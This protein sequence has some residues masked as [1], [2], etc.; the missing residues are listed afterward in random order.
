M[1]TDL[2]EMRAEKDAFFKNHPQS[3]LTAAQRKTFTGLHYFPENPALRLEVSVE[4]FRPQPTVLMQTS[5]GEAREYQK[6]GKFQFTVEG[7]TTALTVYASEHGFFLP[8]VDAL[9]EVET[10]G[11]GRYLEPESL[12]GDRFLVDF[13][14]AY[15]PYCAY[16]EPYWINPLAENRWSCPIT[17]QENRLKIPIRAGEKVYYP[18]E[19][20]EGH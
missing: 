15:N 11:A 4:E 12:D 6:F 2:A 13:N 14:L 17:P 20:P 10:Y 19:P 9:A 7:Q 16:N 3:P 8:F 5:T 1:M 18:E